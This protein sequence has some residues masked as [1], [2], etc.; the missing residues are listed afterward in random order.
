[1]KYRV[2]PKIWDEMN[3][4]EKIHLVVH[5]ARK[6]P[7]TG[8]DRDYLINFLEDVGNSFSEEVET[9]KALAKAG[10]GF[11]TLTMLLFFVAMAG[12]LR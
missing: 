6:H 8:P 9:R 10:M 11:L 7:H 1:M 5:Y 3:D 2:S 12:W 4:L